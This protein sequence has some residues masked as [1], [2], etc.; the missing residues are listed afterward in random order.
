MMR[1]TH[2]GEKEGDAQQG[3]LIEKSKVHQT[4]TIVSIEKQR[5]PCDI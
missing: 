2:V 5:K 1:E 3:N 4:T